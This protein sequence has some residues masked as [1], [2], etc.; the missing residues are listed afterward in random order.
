MKKII[1]G[2]SQCKLL[3]NNCKNGLRT[4]GTMKIMTRGGVTKN[5]TASVNTHQVNSVIVS[6]P[7]GMQFQS[8]Q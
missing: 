6:N 4:N 3:L 5:A 1:C 2:L 8:K 7:W